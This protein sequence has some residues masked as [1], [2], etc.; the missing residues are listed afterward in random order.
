L[1]H[2]GDTINGAA[3]IRAFGAED[4][5]YQESL[6]KVDASNRPYYL[7]WTAQRWVSWRIDVV[8]SFVS[9]LAGAFIVYNIH[10][11]DAGLAGFSLTY[12]LSFTDAILWIMRIY[13][14]VEMNM[15][16]L[17][18]VKEY[19]EVEQEPP[20]V[21]ED[22]QPSSD[23][24]MPGEIKVEGLTV[25][26][27]AEKQPVLNNLSFTIKAGERVGIV[28]RT[29]SGKSTLAISFFRFIEPS[30]GR[31]LIDNVDIGE[32]GL[33]S[34]RKNLTI[35]P[36][37]PVLFT[38]SIR[39]NIDPFEEHN[40]AE[41]WAALKRSH[42]ISANE[43]RPPG[44]ESLDSNVSEGGNNFSQGQRQLLAMARAL[45]RNSKVIIMDEATASVDF[46]TDNRIQQT[47]RE[48]FSSST[49]LCIAHR[50]RTIIDYDKVLVM[51]SG[52]LVEYGTP[53]E[54]LE[55]GGHFKSMCEKSGEYETLQ[56]M[57]FGNK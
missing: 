23:W 31:I 5:F 54:L 43:R 29:G 34:L 24:P 44:L 15:N 45:L 21:I 56:E 19:T 22:T 16:S 51:D 3:T 2:F 27:S 52:R 53:R 26:Y 12:A 8:G 57:A 35:I 9:S 7:L 6:E 25:A 50:L 55:R 36:Q 46:D 4:R 10:Q 14:R 20:Y 1:T 49:L 32:I 41:I 28:G 13:S 47:I 40:D 17:E 18:R 30:S 37:D 11:I 39:S 48:E 42:L 38:G 33:Y